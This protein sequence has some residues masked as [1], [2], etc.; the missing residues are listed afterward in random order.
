MSAAA[1]AFLE[2]SDLRIGF[3]GRA[4]DVPVV[5]GVDF[6]L[7]A[8]ET[9][10]LVGESGSGKSL[11]ALSLIDLLPGGARR[12]GGRIRIGENQLD[13]LSSNAIRKIRGGEIAMIFQDPLS[14]LNPAFTV[15]RQLTDAIRSHHPLSRGAAAKRAEELL[16]LV[17]I[18]SPK[19]RLH[20]FPHEMSGGQR[21]RV[22]IALALAS[23]PKLLIADEPTTALDVTVQAQIMALLARLRQELGLAILLISHNLDLVAEI[24]HRVAV[25]YAGR[26][27]ETNTVEEIFRRPQHPYTRM[28]LDC[29]PRLDDRPGPLA[30]IPGEPPL[31]GKLPSGCPFRP[32][33]PA[34]HERCLA[35]PPAFPQEAGQA[36]CWLAA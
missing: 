35:M 23:G 36:A 7:S 25:M 1:P 21:Q 29:I 22:A 34:A 30:T 28:L 6:A 8:G 33:C 17:G 24:C 10:A 3:P 32:R 13:T 11:T 5:H 26:I 20:S 4:G 27:V 9:L 2:V 31:F 12:L 15:G 18:P 16:D 14:A 19:A